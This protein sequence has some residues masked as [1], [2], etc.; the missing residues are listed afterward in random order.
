MFVEMFCWV[1]PLLLLKRKCLV[2]TLSLNISFLQQTSLHS[3]RY[4]TT[5]N[6]FLNYHMKK[7]LSPFKLLTLEKMSYVIIVKD[8]GKKIMC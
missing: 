6:H 5:K 1:L 8:T 3:K 2:F 7:E 4:W